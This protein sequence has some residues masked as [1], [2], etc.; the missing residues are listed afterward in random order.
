MHSFTVDALGAYQPH[1]IYMWLNIVETVHLQGNY[2][3][4]PPCL[5]S[6]FLPHIQIEQGHR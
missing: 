4:L 6:S 2:Q 1:P 3:L 5:I